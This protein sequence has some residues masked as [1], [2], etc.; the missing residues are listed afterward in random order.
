M[1]WWQRSPVRIFRD[2]ASLAASPTLWLSVEAGLQRAQT[3]VLLASPTAAASPW[4]EREVR[5]WLENR[6]LGTLLIVVTGGRITYDSLRGDFDWSQTDCLP[7][8]LHGACGI[9]PLWT[10]LRFATGPEHLTLRNSRFRS[11]ALGVAAAIRGLAK[12]ELE[13]ADVLVHRRSVRI[14]VGSG[15]V[16]VV[17]AVAAGAASW[18][19]SRESESARTSRLAAESRRLAADALAQLEGGGDVASATV[20]AAV[21]WRL[22]HT[23]EARATLER[24]YS[25][26]SEVARVLGRHTGRVQALAFS[27]DG[28]VLA[29]AGDDG[30]VLQW[31]IADGKP[32][33]VPIGLRPNAWLRP[34][35]SRN[36]THLLVFSKHNTGGSPEFA[37]V[38]V[39]DGEPVPLQADARRTLAS[40]LAGSA[41]V[42]AAV[43]P[44]GRW[45]LIGALNQLAFF[46]TALA[47]VLPVRLGE[48]R[49][50]AA[51]A[52]ADDQSAIVAVLD[53]REGGL[54]V[55]RVS[56]PD[57]KF[58]WGPTL[59]TG[60]GNAFDSQMSVSGRCFAGW[61]ERRYEIGASL[62][63]WRIDHRL[64]LTRA[65]LPQPGETQVE[66]TGRQAPAFD[67][68]CRRLMLSTGSR[69]V[70]WETE[71]QQIVMQ[72][73]IAGEHGAPAALSDDGS[74]VAIVDGPSIIVIALDA[75]EATRELA[76]HCADSR[77]D[78]RCLEQLCDRLTLAGDD[79]RLRRILGEQFDELAPVLRGSSCSAER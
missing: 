50:F 49:S 47:R 6:S 66:H 60:A 75:D 74:R 24:V 27:P 17:L 1:P 78:D 4:V 69:L 57:G 5:W 71:T 67:A 52:F 55:A 26:S 70:V 2:D 44:D 43:S 73:A 21:A 39:A 72:R 59:R 29:T 31:R 35:Y 22:A 23:A 54:R 18:V 11:A 7:P 51:A 48:S 33:G 41:G 65:A 61:G 14:V 56:L 45:A 12:D 19:A 58:T 34:Q 37:L 77:I 3:F 53:H 32:V 15:L 79:A 25:K 62:G 46:D 40:A 10:D 20:K 76:T 36:G 38:R 30:A 64:V 13:N 42:Q 16:M 8:A 28:K 68:G 63:A 9:E